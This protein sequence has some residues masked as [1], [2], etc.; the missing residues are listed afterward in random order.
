[1]VCSRGAGILFG[2]VSRVQLSRDLVGS[3]SGC[4]TFSEK[5]YRVSLPLAGTWQFRASA[6]LHCQEKVCAGNARG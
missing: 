5:R 3:R 1:M 4:Q 2:V 6:E